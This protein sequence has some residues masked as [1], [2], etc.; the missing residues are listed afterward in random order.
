MAQ[1]EHPRARLY[2]ATSLT[3]ASV[4]LGPERAHYLRHVLRMS[5]G[6]GLALF[7]A[8]DGEREARI[9]AFG[10]G[11]CEVAVGAQRRA[12]RAEANLWL[13]FAPI[14]RA[15]IDGMIEKATELGVSTFRPVFTQHTAMTR[16]NLERLKTIAIEAAEQCERLTVPDIHPP[17]YLADALRAWPSGRSLLLC[18]ETGRSEPIGHSL[19]RQKP[20]HGY[21]ILVGPE[22]GFAAAELDGLRKLPFVTPVG[23]GPRVLR[24]DTAALAALSVVQALVGDGHMSTPG[25]AQHAT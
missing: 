25:R 20:L 6:D 7:N 16:I 4:R 17:Q 12:P 9:A 1:S 19:T 8:T 5:T 14:K 2:V 18:D 23:L 11:W 24:A 13:L 21:G 22:G 3:A 15:R 10:K